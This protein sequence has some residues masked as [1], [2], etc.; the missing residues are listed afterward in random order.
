MGENQENFRD[1]LTKMAQIVELSEDVF[2]NS[3]KITI[4]VVLDEYEFNDISRNL[5]KNNKDERAIIS[6]G[7]VEFIFLK[8]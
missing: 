5:N 1:K 7:D 6:I 4:N 2:K 8:K 3:K